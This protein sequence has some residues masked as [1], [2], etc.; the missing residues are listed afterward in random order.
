MKDIV[1]DPVSP[2]KENVDAPPTSPPV[3]VPGDQSAVRR[4]HAGQSE[5]SGGGSK[6]GRNPAGDGEGISRSE[7]DIWVVESPTRFSAL[8]VWAAVGFASLTVWAAVIWM[9]AVLL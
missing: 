2:A 7:P 3:C 4:T 6:Q 9:L 8:G 1:R 5:P